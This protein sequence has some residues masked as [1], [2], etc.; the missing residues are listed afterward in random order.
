MTL[1]PLNWSPERW[2]K[3]ARTVRVSAHTALAEYEIM[4]AR[5][6]TATPVA[7]FFALAASGVDDWRFPDDG[8]R[9]AEGTLKITGQRNDE[10]RLIGL[11]VQAIGGVALERYAGQQAQIVADKTT[12]LPIAFDANG[13]AL[14][15]LIGS[16]LAEAAFSRFTVQ[17][18]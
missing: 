9:D 18:A 4:Q 16:E 17:L 2:R 13:T 14:L 12:I 3:L 8:L 6:V 11:A 5:Q 7:E 10:G 15:S 1:P